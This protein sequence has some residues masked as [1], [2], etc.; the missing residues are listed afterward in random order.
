MS[1]Q[2]KDNRIG[3]EPAAVPM[4]TVVLPYSNG[5][6]QSLRRGMEP[7]LEDRDMYRRLQV[8]LMP[9]AAAPDCPVNAPV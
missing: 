1:R 5:G 3:L 9:R 4:V 8:Q 2:T 7:E 6:Q